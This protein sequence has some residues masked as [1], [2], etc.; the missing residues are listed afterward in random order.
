MKKV[1]LAL[2]KLYQFSRPLRP[3]SC[4]FYPSCSDY[5]Y[6]CLDRHGFFKGS[7]LS[8]FRILKCHPLSAGGIDDIP[9]KFSWGF[10]S[11]LTSKR[12]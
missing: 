11:S 8:V 10:F 2:I 3:P 6:G 1:L 7:L 9:D 5:A 12:V 4:R